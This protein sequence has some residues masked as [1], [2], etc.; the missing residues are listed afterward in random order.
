M[1]RKYYFN[2]NYFEKI[3]T[4]EKAYFL[5][6]LMADGYV[7][8]TE[9]FISLALKNED[10][11]ILYMLKKEL[12]SDA[13]LGNKKNCTQKVFTM[14]SKK[15]VNDLKQ[16]GL[17]R[18]KTFTLQF[19]I[20]PKR[21][22]RHFIRGYF[23]GDGY[24]G[25]RQCTLIIASDAFLESFLDFFKKEFNKDLYVHE[26]KNSYRVNLNKRDADIV[27]YIYKGAKVYLDRKY[28]NFKKYW[29]S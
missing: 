3:D 4:E 12:N 8:T 24:V 17:T 11:G 29:L 6:L 16:L 23:D 14:C 5:G 26:I 25:E 21:L 2:E 18:N 19:P 28:K 1:A 20:I 13:P 9:R 27:N 10:C 15:L 22:I 7:A